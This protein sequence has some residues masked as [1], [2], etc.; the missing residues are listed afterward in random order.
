MRYLRF[1]GDA[2]S[3]VYPTLLQHVPVW[4]RYII[5]ALTGHACKCYRASLE[6]LAA[7]NAKYKGKGGLTG[8]KM[9]RRLTTAARCAIKMQSKEEDKTKGLALLKKDLINGPYHCFGYHS[10]CS[11]DFC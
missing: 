10:N 1:I 9:R 7:N 2:D 5:S 3:S 4:G 6:K 11:P 8:K